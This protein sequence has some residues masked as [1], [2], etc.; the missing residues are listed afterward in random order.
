MIKKILFGIMLVTTI[1]LAKTTVGESNGYNGKITA[2][3]TTE[4]EKIQKI[5]V[6]AEKGNSRLKKAI[7]G[8]VPQIIEK[9]S[10]DVINVAGASVT[11]SAIK[12]A[13]EKALKK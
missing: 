13:V 9:N 4:N 5:D 12:E 2:T 6:V 3:V 1:A 7:K 10:T 11:S 8:I